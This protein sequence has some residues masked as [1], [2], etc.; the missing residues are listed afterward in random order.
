[1]GKPSSFKDEQLSLDFNHSNSLNLVP[2]KRSFRGEFQKK[3]LLEV[4]K[5]PY[6]KIR[7]YKQI[8]EAMDSKAYRAVGTAIGKNP[9]PLIIPCHRVVKSDLSVGGFYGGTEMKKDILQNEGISIVN[10]KIRL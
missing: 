5:I 2:R 6:G 8:A 9:L 4:K 10:N 1:H 3:V 7:T